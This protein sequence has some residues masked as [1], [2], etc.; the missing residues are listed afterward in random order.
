LVEHIVD[1]FACPSTDVRIDDIP[2][3]KGVMS[4]PIR[5]DCVC[6]MFEIPSLA[7][8]KVI[9]GNDVLS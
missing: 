6:D 3:E 1:T 2:F 4:P 7:S 8:C 5:A 9:E